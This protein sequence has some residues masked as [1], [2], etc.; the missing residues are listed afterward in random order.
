MSYYKLNIV[1]V[2]GNRIFLTNDCWDNHIVVRHPIMIHFLKDVKETIKNPDCIYRSKSDY[3][4]CLYYRLSNTKFGRVY[5]L[6][7]IDTKIKKKVGY[8]KTALLVDK[9]KGGELIWRKKS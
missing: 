5:I 6:V 7:V 1:D 9:L 3:L 4:T 2:Q 8:V